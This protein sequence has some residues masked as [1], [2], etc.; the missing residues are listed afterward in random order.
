MVNYPD[1]KKPIEFRFPT[2]AEW[3]FVV[4]LVLSL[5]VSFFFIPQTNTDTYLLYVSFFLLSTFFVFLSDLSNNKRVGIFLFAIGMILLG[6]IMAFRNKTGI[7]DYAYEKFF[8]KVVNGD[9]KDVFLHADLETGYL[10]LNFIIASLGI[11][12]YCYAMTIISY[13][14]FLFW[15]LAFWRYRERCN[16]SVMI[17]L[18]WSN[19]YFF[20]LSAGLV[21]IFLSLPLAL[22]AIEMISSKKIKSFVFMVLAASLFHRSALILL[23]LT[24]LF[25]EKIIDHWKLFVGSLTFLIPVFFVFIA[26]VIVPMLGSRYANYG[27]IGELSASIGKFDILPLW[28]MGFYYF[29]FIQK[30]NKRLY[31]LGMVTLS[32]SIIF[33]ICSSLVPL[34][35]L[36][37]FANLGILI[38]ASNI[39]KQKPVGIFEMFVP[40]IFVVYSCIYVMHTNFLNPFNMAHLFPY[41]T[42]LF[43]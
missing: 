5:T 38:I 23:L 17:L 1:I 24:P 39:F 12:D 19:Y 2:D 9:I 4:T 21:R 27:N 30:T 42:Y 11:T 22:I 14:S 43:E 36:I 34:G 8:L 37:F 32:L 26:K 35:R 29:Q 33:S 3:L 25:F 6:S 7:D 41:Q 28:I 40:C 18:L 20:V 13:L 10:F 16:L 31:T 15:G